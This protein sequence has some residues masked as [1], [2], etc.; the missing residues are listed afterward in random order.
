ML[1]AA[2]DPGANSAH[3]HLDTRA[4]PAPAGRYLGRV[5]P[6]LRVPT[7]HRPHSGTLRAARQPPALRDLPTGRLSRRSDVVARRSWSSLAREG[8]AYRP[9]AILGAHSATATSMLSTSR[10]LTNPK[11]WRPGMGALGSDLRAG[12]FTT[13]STVVSG[14]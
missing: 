1:R 4:G 14:T 9:R 6:D 5:L 13:S 11:M 10:V 7:L 2:Y 12:L 8:S 3:T